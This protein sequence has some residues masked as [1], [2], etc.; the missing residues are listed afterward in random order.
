MKHLDGID[1]KLLAQPGKGLEEDE[2]IPGWNILGVAARAALRLGVNPRFRAGSKFSYALF[3]A[4]AAARQMKAVT[5]LDGI[6]DAVVSAPLR[7]VLDQS[8][9]VIDDFHAIGGKIGNYAHGGPTHRSDANRRA[10]QI[11]FN[12]PQDRILI[13][14]LDG[15]RCEGG[16]VALCYLGRR[17]E[18]ELAFGARPRAVKVGHD[19]VQ[20]AQNDAAIEQLKLRWLG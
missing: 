5:D 20:F 9:R 19:F 11:F 18:N 6:I 12:K 2:C 4:S 10:A 8:D 14:G 16:E 15:A 7:G 1:A 3:G 17:V 13:V